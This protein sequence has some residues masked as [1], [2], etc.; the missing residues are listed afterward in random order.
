MEIF[1]RIYSTPAEHLAC[2]EAL[3]DFSEE[4]PGHPGFLR[5][6]ESEISFVVLGYSKILQEEVYEKVCSET[7]TPIFRRCTG[8]GT[9]LQGIGCFNYCLVLPIDSRAEFGSIT[10][11]NSFIM[12]THA[13]GFRTLL[14]GKIEI[15]GCTD[16]TLDGLK[17]SGNSQR[18]KRRFLLFHG[19]FLLNFD[20]SFIEKILRIPQQQPEYRKNRKHSEFI[21]NIGQNAF[22]IRETIAN[23]WRK[24][25]PIT[26]H[27]GVE[28]D[29]RVE[30]L[31]KQKYSQDLW[32]RKA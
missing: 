12:Q 1:D 27:K 16:L 9:V 13:Q 14:K 24:Y 2:D 5:F 17:F 18:R 31:V 6:W 28:I 26:T 11:T 4:N 25:F 19:S 15:Q 10:S 22:R 8:G 23:T 21:V 20:L 29:E 30:D 32:N 3:L 7:H